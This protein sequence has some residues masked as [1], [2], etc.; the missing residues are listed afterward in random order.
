MSATLDPDIFTNYFDSCP[1]LY[2]EGREHPVHILHAE[3]EQPNYLESAIV[4]IL[5]I[6]KEAPAK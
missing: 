2:I 5:Q 6:N 1:P 3:E 4:T